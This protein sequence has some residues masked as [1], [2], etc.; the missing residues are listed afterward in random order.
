[1]EFQDKSPTRRPIVLSTG[2]PVLR[3][4]VLRIA[5]AAECTV[6][7]RNLPVGIA[8]PGTPPSRIEWDEADAILLDV[9]HAREA[10]S[11]RLPRRDAIFVLGRGE[12]GVDQWRAAT[13]V[14]ASHVLGLPQDEATLIGLLGRE[15]DRT[16]G[17]GGVITVVGGR[18]GAGTST[19][20]VALALSASAAGSRTL[21]VD[22][23]SYGPGLDLLLG[24]EE[25]PG[26]RW[27]G[28]V[29]EAGRISGDAL[30]SAVPS[31]GSLAVLS[32][33]RADSGSSGL[34]ATA[35]AA[36]VDAGRRSGDLVVC[37]VPRHPG[38]HTDVFHDAADLVVL[39]VPAEIGAVAGAENLLAYLRG[40]NS[41]VGLVV[42]GP[43]P[44]GLRG[45]DIA[46][47]LRL[48][49]LATMRPE[50]GLAQR[51]ERG[52]LGL[53]RRSPL[54]DAAESILATFA[55]KPAPRRWAA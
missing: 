17:D 2:D 3:D 25:Q 55:R 13:A 23:D 14:G 7:E 31:S 6:L 35:C 28:L 49:L 32:A 45:A 39:V 38:P 48:P 36:V 54:T 12:P 29:V 9:D 27:S 18:G 22:G 33:G 30:H 5:A 15:H 44:G 26:L 21:L 41:N 51:I 11:R 8:G 4:E 53:G 37:D 1:M 19:L 47:A 42:R 24:W 10:S 50:P 20:A 16:E 46:D 40:R 43:A 52:G 34:D